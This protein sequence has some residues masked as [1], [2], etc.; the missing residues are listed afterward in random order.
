MAHDFNN[1]LTVVIGGAEL[2]RLELGVQTVPNVAQ[3][4]L[5]TPSTAGGGLANTGSSEQS[6]DAH[7]NSNHAQDAAVKSTHSQQNV[8][9]LI[10]HIITAANAGADITKAL[11]AYARKQPMQLESVNLNRFLA[12][13]V[14]LVARTLG[15]TIEVELDMSATPPLDVVLD[16]AQL[17]SV[18]INLCLNARDAQSNSG[19]ITVKLDL[20]R[21]Q[22]ARISVKDTGVGMNEEQIQ[23][24]VEPF[25]TTKRESQ[26]NGLGLS[27]VYGFSKQVG[28]DLEIHS[29]PG[30]GT[31]VSILLP[32]GITPDIIVPEVQAND[33]GVKSVLNN[34]RSKT[35]GSPAKVAL[36]KTAL[37]TGN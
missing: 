22:W 32:A 16:P 15:G 7:N 25:Y 37:R 21:E 18:L 30:E 4:P 27:M 24:A 35:G 3:A 31:E 13:R 34:P 36:A 17:T 19:T 1:L 8:A 2:L 23:R 5:T 28:G 6:G 29:S 20:V 33:L 12:D 14:P 10:E 26:G 11:M 9:S